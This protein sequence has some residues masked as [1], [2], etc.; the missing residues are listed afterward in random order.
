MPARAR[1]SPDFSRIVNKTQF[2][3]IKAMLDNTTG[4]IVLGG[5]TDEADLFIEPTVVVVDRVDDSMMADESFGPIWSIMPYDSLEEAIDIAH[6]VDP[7]PLA[8]YTFGSDEDNEK[9]THAA[10]LAPFPDASC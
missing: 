6:K 8:L 1:A 4:T 3:R 2:D 9:G 10:D 5:A 7:T